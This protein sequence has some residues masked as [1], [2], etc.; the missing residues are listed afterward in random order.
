MF[1]VLLILIAYYVTFKLCK[2]AATDTQELEDKLFL[3][4]YVNTK[5]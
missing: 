3:E 4:T 2:S 1:I 5:H